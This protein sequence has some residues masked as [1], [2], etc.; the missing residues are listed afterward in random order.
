ME[1]GARAMRRWGEVSR[2]LQAERPLLPHWYLA[3]LGVDPDWQGQGLGGRLLEA[4]LA[5]ADRD[6][7]PAYLECDREASL[8]VYTRRGF[9]EREVREVHGVACHLLGRGFVDDPR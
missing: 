9:V 7:A 6:G 8:L 1:Q 3:L 4:F 5:L 2:A